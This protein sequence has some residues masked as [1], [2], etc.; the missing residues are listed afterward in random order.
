VFDPADGRVLG[1][2]AVGADG[3]DKRLDVLA[4]AIHARMTVRDLT[5]LE[6]SYAPPFGSAKDAVNIAGYAATNLLDGV[7]DSVQWS[8]LAGLQLVAPE[9][10]TPA[11]TAA[12]AAAATPADAK[13]RA[14][15]V[16]VREPGELKTAGAIPGAV[17]IP[18]PQLRGRL[19]ELEP[20]RSAGV[21]VLV[22]CAVGMRGYMGCRILTAAGFGHVRNVDGGYKTYAAATKKV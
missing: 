4:T 14:V 8:D 10:L 11:A 20:A 17:N 22:S 16:D 5:E 9:A 12:A 21:P 6:L 13:P 19:A 7:V 18:L 1:A 15:L 2:Q 3:V